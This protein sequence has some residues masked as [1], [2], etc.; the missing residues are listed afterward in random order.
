MSLAEK[1]A[2]I[3][4]AEFDILGDDVNKQVELLNDIEAWVNRIKSMV[5][6]DH[7]RCSECNRS[8]C[9]IAIHSRPT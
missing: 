6:T 4:K 7:V 3:I 1:L 2:K 9:I 8:H 5:L